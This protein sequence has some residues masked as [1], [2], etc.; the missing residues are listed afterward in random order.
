MILRLVTIVLLIFIWF[1]VAQIHE[2][3]KPIKV[4]AQ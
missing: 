3:L 1:Q 4:L 2:L